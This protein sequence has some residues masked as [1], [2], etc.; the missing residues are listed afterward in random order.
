M[1]TFRTTQ[2]EIPN[3][4]IDLGVGQPSLSLLPLDALREAADHRLRQ[5]N[6][7]LLAYG[8]DQGDGAFRTALGAF[9]ARRYRMPVDASRLMISASASQALD[10]I[11]TRFTKPGDTIFVEEPTYFLAL[12]VFRDH[13]L[14]VVGIP[15]DGDGVRIDALDAALAVHTPV[16]FYTIP[17]FQNPSAVTMTAERRAELV[18]RSLSHDF[19]V[20]AD[21][22]YHLLDFDTD[23]DAHAEAAPLRP[24]PLA[25]YADSAR[26]LSLGSFSKITAP[27][28]RL[29]WIQASPALIDTL[30][31]SGVIESGGGLNPFTSGVMQSMLDLG[32]A[33]AC[34]DRLRG[35]YRER[36]RVLCDALRM[37]MPAA[38]FLEP[39]GGFFV[40]VALPAGVTARALQPLARERGAHFQPGYRFGAGA[41]LESRIRLSFAYYEPAEL[42]EGVRRVGAAA[43]ALGSA[44]GSVTTL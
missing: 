16:M 36:S 9:L 13:G 25:S 1:S 39:E 22:V 8:A 26:V 21:E 28:L 10:L 24:L 23:T 14:N 17:T 3:G 7:E 2:L 32:L 27:G 43:G 4:M 15:I 42:V 20:V 18:A 44:L 19:L 41:M 11:C 5:P 33:D 12:L 38:H 35:V 40:W 34:L 37:H 31:A 6:P 29:G 30:I